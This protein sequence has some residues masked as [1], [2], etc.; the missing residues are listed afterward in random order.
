[1]E[2]KYKG[3]LKA[4]NTWYF[5]DA[6]DFSKVERN[7]EIYP[8][9]KCQFSNWQDC[10]G[11]DIYQGDFLKLVEGVSMP[12]VYGSVRCDNGVFYVSDGEN[13]ENKVPLSQTLTFKNYK[14]EVVGNEWNIL[15]Q[16]RSAW[17]IANETEFYEWVKSK[18]ADVLTEP[19]NG[20]NFSVGETVIYTNGYGAKFKVK[21][22]GFCAEPQVIGGEYRTV[23]L[24]TSNPYP[25]YPYDAK[26]LTKIY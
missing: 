5:G 10:K 3:I 13:N 22:L 23:Y 19:V 6:L 25:N 8:I 17:S 2:T 24:D 1:M 15:G 9:S 16:P 18:H 26:N 4:T 12:Y 7:G 14:F 11:N 20:E 21:I